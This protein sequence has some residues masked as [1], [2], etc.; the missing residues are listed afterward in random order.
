VAYRGGTKPLCTENET[1]CLDTVSTR[2][3]SRLQ[4]LHA[5]LRFAEISL[6]NGSVMVPRYAPVMAD[7]CD[8]GAGE[9]R[10]MAGVTL[11]PVVSWAHDAA[12]CAGP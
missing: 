12:G 7:W 6:G 2:P 1:L 11:G 4:S 8:I 3:Y 10:A 9:L 5:E